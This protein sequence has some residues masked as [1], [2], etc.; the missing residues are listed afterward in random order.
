MHVGWTQALTNRFGDELAL[1]NGLHSY[2]GLLKAI[3]YVG[4]SRDL[5]EALPARQGT[6]SSNDIRDSWARLGLITIPVKRRRL[7]P[8]AYPC[9]VISPSG[10]ITIA[11]G[12][13]AAGYLVMTG[14]SWDET[15]TIKRLPRGQVFVAEEQDRKT[16]V[17]QA[18]ARAWVRSVFS[19]FRP[20]LNSAILSAFMI[21]LLSL[22]GPLAIMMVYDQVIAKESSDLL[23][24]LLIGVVAAAVLEIVLRALRA[25]S[26]AYVGAKLDYQI[27]SRVFEQVLHLPPLF[28][29]RAP[30][31]G[32]MARIR[33]FDSFREIFSGPIAALILDLPFTLLFMVIIFIIAG[34]LVLVPVVLM[35]LY[36]IFGSLVL[37]EIRRRTGEAGKARSARYG[38]LVELV[39]SMRSLKEQN[40]ER[41]WKSRFRNLSADATWENYAVNKLSGTANSVAQAMMFGSGVATLGFGVGQVIAGSMSMGA[42]IATMMLVWRVLAPIQTIFSLANRVEQLKQ[43]IRQFTDLIGYRREQEPGDGPSVPLTFR[44]HLTLN[45]ISMRYSRDANPALLGVA[46]D[47]KPGELIGVVGESGSGKSTLAKLAIG[48][49]E[50]QAG[51]IM[52]DGVDIRQLLPITLRQ[53]VGYVPQENHTFPGTIRENILMSD[54]AASEERLRH[55]CRMA[56]ILH[57]IEALPQ[58]FETEFRDGMESGAPQSFVRQISL[59]RAFLKECPVYVLD[60]PSA[61]LDEEDARAFL[62]ALEYL[63]ERSTVIMI[64][65][66]PL[67]MRL[68]D[69][70]LV[71]DNGQQVMLDSVEPVVEWLLKRNAERY[72]RHLEAQQSEPRQKELR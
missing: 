72:Q 13:S 42:L 71:L 48:L 28:T 34:P 46:L 26:L 51:S 38:F 22:V 45:R 68:C 58:G 35:G 56:G 31:S 11:L 44:G 12:K 40:G 43:S 37:P 49:Y 4:S 54:P 66:R 2:Y 32:Q 69:R 30:V 15:D 33:E 18:A 17:G 55:A 20:I 7:P 63:R 70:V 8:S 27:A 3:G 29:E 39:W 41:L 50:P 24:S 14:K 47:I 62:R 61:A 25:H 60:E 52:M 53:T 64:T 10:K 19:E 1:G 36:F 9:A 59:A 65:Q 6:F 16:A 5:L 21:N 67:H 57:K 23:Q